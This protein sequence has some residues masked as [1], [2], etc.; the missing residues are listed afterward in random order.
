MKIRN[1][2]V[3]LR[4]KLELLS[5]VLIDGKDND[6]QLYFKGEKSI[7]SEHTYFPVESR[8]CT[9]ANLIHCKVRSGGLIRADFQQKYSTDCDISFIEQDVGGGDNERVFE[10]RFS[11]GPV[12]VVFGVKLT[13]EEL[14]PETIDNESMMTFHQFQEIYSEK[15]GEC[16]FS[17]VTLSSNYEQVQAE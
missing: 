1:E 12:S 2:V 10:A 15:I 3:D 8:P 16:N 17:S 4:Q 7:D 6:E 9:L 14:L 5:S 11:P 13:T